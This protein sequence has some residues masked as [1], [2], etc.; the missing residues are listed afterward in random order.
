MSQCFV[1]EE[2]CPGGKRKELLNFTL[3]VNQSLFSFFS[4]RLAFVCHLCFV[5]LNLALKEGNVS[6][7]VKKIPPGTLWVSHLMRAM[8]P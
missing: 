6:L 1:F 3:F 2:A 8:N 5:V 7:P 4:L